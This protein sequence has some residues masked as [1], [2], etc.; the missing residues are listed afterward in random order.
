MYR[1][2]LARLETFE[3]AGQVERLQ[4]AVNGS[5]KRLPVRYR[6]A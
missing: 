6:F 1:H 5:V 3:L 2:L 4:S